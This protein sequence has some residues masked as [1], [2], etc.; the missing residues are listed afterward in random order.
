MEINKEI[1]K[2]GVIGAGV[3]GLSCAIQF[4][5]SGYHHVTILAR[6]TS[7]DTTSDIAPAIWRL[8]FSKM[9]PKAAILRWAKDSLNIF[10]PLIN[11]SE[12]GVSWTNLIEIYDH[13]IPMPKWMK[14]VEPT[15]K[16]SVVLHSPYY[17]C[18]HV[19]T[20]DATTYL[21][22]LLNR[23]MQLGGVLRQEEV[24]NLNELD[25]YQIVV[26][27]T[28]LGAKYLVNDTTVFPIKG[29]I[30]RLTK[31]KDLSYSL[32]ALHNNEIT[33]IYPREKDC[34]IGG[35]MEKNNWDLKPNAK[36]AMNIMKRA[37][38]LCPLLVRSKILEHKVGLRPGRSAIRLEGEIN[39]K[40]RLLI[41]N[42]GHANAGFTLSWG[43]AAQVVRIME[44]YWRGK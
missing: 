25:H 41:H 22:F 38:T 12:S 3:S 42:Y 44:K 31:P 19:P 26:N 21:Q 28:G 11:E 2:I 10:K 23:L 34:I 15:N 35:T 6:E 18:V 29:Q 43:C 13:K 24:T 4:L 8:P 36:I 1:I 30:I 20:I 9:E 17:F 7:P 37:L 32:V 5:K 39:A 14:Y 27:C 33:Y 40:N 16:P